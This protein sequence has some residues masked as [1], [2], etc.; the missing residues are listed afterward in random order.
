[1][2]K[3]LFILLI[4]LLPLL[5]VSQESKKQFGIKFSGFVKTDFML[6]SRQTVTAREGHFLLW[7]AAKSYDLM[8]ED[9]NAHAKTTFLAVQSRFVWENNG[10]RCI[11]CK[12][13][14]D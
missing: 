14:P 5:S 8:G 6:D 11:W 9:I 4:T 2:K 3:N 13:F 1:M 10:T 7:P 12:N